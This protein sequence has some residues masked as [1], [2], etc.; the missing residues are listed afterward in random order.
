MGRGWL[1]GGIAV[2]GLSAVAVNVVLLRVD[3]APWLGDFAQWVVM[4]QLFLGLPLWI[5]L[6]RT[7]G[8]ETS[9]EVPVRL[10]PAVVAFLA[11]EASI[12]LTAR[13]G[14]LT[15]DL[16]RALAVL[17]GRTYLFALVE[18]LWFREIW[19]K[20]TRHRFATSVLAGSALFGLFH[21]WQGPDAVMRTLSIGLVYG[22][23]RFL[24]TPFWVVAA[25]HALI[26][27]LNNG[28]LLAV[29]S[30]VE[31]STQTAIVLSASL[32]TSAVLLLLAGLF[33]RSTETPAMSWTIPL[34]L[35]AS[36]LV[37]GLI[38]PFVAACSSAPAD[39][40]PPQVVRTEP[41]N[42]AQDV[43]ANLDRITVYFDEPMMTDGY[44][45]VTDKDAAFPKT[46]GNPTFSEDGKSV[47]LPVTL[48]PG[49]RYAVW[50]NG[51]R[52]QNFK[53]VAGNSVK[54]FRLEFATIPAE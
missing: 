2:F 52:A 3:A 46:T 8:E 42:E 31:P 20:A 39:Q 27:G 32:F 45:W 14:Y 17:L 51:Q 48:E 10:W 21:L 34:S 29:E 43:P 53:D 25:L 44:S 35:L 54:P 5:L 12:L 13:H 38:I 37:V 30:S 19:F 1:W 7:R 16:P 36:A 23:V 11:V 28:L 50:I 47:S 41:A 6:R 15:E 22:T 9:A 24:G 40:T 33:E 4:G 49:Q 18:E 26:N